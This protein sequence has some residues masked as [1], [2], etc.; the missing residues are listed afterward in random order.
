MAQ[1]M[2]M[3][4]WSSEL[5]LCPSLAGERVLCFHGPLLYEAKV[6]VCVWLQLAPAAPQ[7]NKE[8]LQ[9]ACWASRWDQGLELK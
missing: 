5:F 3:L 8:M 7:E 6:G 1:V 4:L 9:F 2:E